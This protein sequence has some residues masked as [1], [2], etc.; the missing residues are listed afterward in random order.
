MRTERRQ[1]AEEKGAK[2]AAKLT[3]PLVLLILP[4]LLIVLLGPAM[5]KLLASFSG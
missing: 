2:V 1:I 5:I 4:V 3:L